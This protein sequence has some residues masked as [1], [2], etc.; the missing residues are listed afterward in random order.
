MYGE[1]LYEIILN[2]DPVVHKERLFNGKKYKRG[3]LYKDQTQ[4]VT[5]SFIK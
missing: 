3:T 2:K 1:N 4:S 5:G